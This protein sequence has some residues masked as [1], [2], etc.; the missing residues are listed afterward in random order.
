MSVAVIDQTPTIGSTI[1]RGDVLT[2]TLLHDD[3]SDAVIAVTYPDS[4]REIV[5]SGGAFS[6]LFARESS[7]ST[8]SG[9]TIFSVIRTGG[10]SSSP[11][12]TADEAENSPDGWGHPWGG[13]GGEFV[14]SGGYHGSLP[15]VLSAQ[16]GPDLAPIVGGLGLSSFLPANLT[17]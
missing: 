1:A 11:T 16:P 14:Q 4:R 2:F 10:W 15:I 13:G 6:P 3:L 8:N 5:F 12:I 17:R 9:L 7:T